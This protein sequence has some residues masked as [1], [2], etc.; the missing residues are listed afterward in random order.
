[1]IQVSSQ[2]FENDSFREF[3]GACTSRNLSWGIENRYFIPESRL[4]QLKDVL[5]S[6]LYYHH[7]SFDFGDE[8]CA[9][10]YPKTAQA[11]MTLRSGLPHL[12]T[13]QTGHFTEVIGAEFG[14]HILGF[15]T[16]AV[17]PKR[18]NPNPDQAMKGTD[19][20]GIQLSKKPP[21]LLLGE[22]KYRENYDGN[23][24]KDS[25]KHLLS[26][27]NSEATKILFMWREVLRLQGIKHNLDYACSPSTTR[28]ALI[29][30]ITQ[31][32]PQQPFAPLDE[33]CKTQ[34]LPN[35]L[36]VHIEIEN[37]KAHLP[38]LFPC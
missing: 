38:A 36:T 15:D 8:L 5:I 30:S 27:C 16:T 3:L 6:T 35:L 1:M 17:L 33:L 20:I 34:P 9:L 28:T 23:A 19:I 29:L 14:H 26:L 21:T 2:R 32:R 12:Y 24:I 11:L 22:A 10:G 18:L 13:T 37:L 7:S 4:L 25:H 31:N